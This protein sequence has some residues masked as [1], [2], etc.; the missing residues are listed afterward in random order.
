MITESTHSVNLARARV[1]VVDDHPGT[2]TTLA[3][4][5]SQLGPAIEVISATSAKSALD[6]VRDGAVDLLITD[7]M[8]PDMN[9]L[10]LIEN[11]QG[12]PGGRPSFTI[13]ITAYDVPGLRE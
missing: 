10:E 6:Q 13:L 2:A 5:L 9:G 1:L 3:R 8:M 4:A 7:M 11:L 12:H